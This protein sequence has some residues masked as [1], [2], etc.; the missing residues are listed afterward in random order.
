MPVNCSRIAA[1][2]GIRVISAHR[3]ED[4]TVPAGI[5]IRE[6]R[7]RRQERDDR[8][9]HSQKACKISVTT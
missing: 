2:G 9:L 4:I 7:D 6:R 3:F 1:G 8:F 5:L